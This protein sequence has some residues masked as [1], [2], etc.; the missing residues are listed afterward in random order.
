MD[1][2]SRHISEMVRNTTYEPLHVYFFTNSLLYIARKGN[3]LPQCPNLSF[4]YDI[5]R[6]GWPSIIIGF[7]RKSL[8]HTQQTISHI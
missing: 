7:I 6:I 2:A 3:G 5:L 8:A 4:Q 1:S